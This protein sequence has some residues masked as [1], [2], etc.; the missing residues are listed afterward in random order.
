MI[1]FGKY[2]GS[3]VEQVFPKDP[4]VVVNLAMYFVDELYKHY[5]EGIK[6]PGVPFGEA[7]RVDA[8]ELIIRRILGKRDVFDYRLD[9]QNPNVVRAY[10]YSI[11]RQIRDRAW[12][13]VLEAAPLAEQKK[14]VLS[15][16][17]NFLDV[18]KCCGVNGLNKEF[19]E[20]LKIDVENPDAV[21]AAR[22]FCSTKRICLECARP[23]TKSSA[24]TPNE[25][26]NERF[27][28]RMCWYKIREKYPCYHDRD[29]EGPYVPCKHRETPEQRLEREK[30]ENQ[31]KRK[32]TEDDDEADKN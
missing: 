2:A 20:R 14:M 11:C 15:E 32:R 25:G 7:H 4:E 23:M 18:E 28:H 1:K 13:D 30:W 12:W 10:G 22:A 24:A 16:R 17:D 19:F 9:M 31:W 5:D 26:Y 8:N 27:I 3:T 21:A 29:Y 6:T